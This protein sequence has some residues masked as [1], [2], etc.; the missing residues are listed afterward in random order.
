MAVRTTMCRLVGRHQRF[1]ETYYLHLQDFSSPEGGY[2]MFLRNVG[3]YL[4]VYSRRKIN[5]SLNYVTVREA[6]KMERARG[7]KSANSLSE[8]V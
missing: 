6:G 5:P 1:G 7:S 4:R 2:S 8:H 3:V